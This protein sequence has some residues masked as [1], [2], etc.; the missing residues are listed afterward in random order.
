MTAPALLVQLA[1]PALGRPHV[2]RL[3]GD[4]LRLASE[5]LS[6]L[7]LARRALAAGQ[8]FA[9][10]IERTEWQAPLPIDA[11]LKDHVL[12]SPVTHEDPTH[13]HATGTG[14]THLGSADARDRMHVTDAA[15]TD[16]MRMFRDG[17][18]GGRP[19]GHRPGAQ[20]EWFYK[21]NGHAM[22]APGQPITAPAFSLD[23]G[24]EPELAGIYLI[25]GDGTPVRLGF[26]LANEF[27]DHVLEKQNYLLLAHSKLRPFSIGPAL[28]TGPAPSDIAGISR[29]LRDGAC[30]WSKPF[31]TGEANMSHSIANLEHHHFKYEIFRRPGDVHV[32]MFGTATLSFA[33]GLRCKDGDIYEISAQG[34]GPSLRNPL[35][36]LPDPAATRR[37]IRTL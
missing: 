25:D 21:G 18:A 11:A 23:A 1:D 37:P 32:H 8:T 7:D 31:L 33:D 34:F 22:A 6:T 30:I 9:E 19:D 26:A 5:V 4:S 36:W 2:A 16:S 17:L 27:S 35:R 3:D 28:R 20:P 13:L 10:T 14:L 29:V 12:L 24:E 15:T